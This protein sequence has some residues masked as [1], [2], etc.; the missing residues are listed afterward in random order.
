MEGSGRQRIVK[1][2]GTVKD[3]G[4]KGKAK[5]SGRQGK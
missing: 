4:R 3:S 1:G 5:N 2:G